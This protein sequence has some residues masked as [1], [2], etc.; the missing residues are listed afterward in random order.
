[1]TLDKILSIKTFAEAQALISRCKTPQGLF[2]WII[3]KKSLQ[4]KQDLTTKAF[5]A[6]SVLVHP[7]KNPAAKAR[8][9]IAF[10]ALEG[11]RTQADEICSGVKKKNIHDNGV[12]VNPVVFSTKHGTYTAVRR[13]AEGATCTVF[14]GTLQSKGQVSGLE[15]LMRVPNSYRDNDL[16]KREAVAFGVMRNKEKEMGKTPEGKEAAKRFMARLPGFLG[17]V[18]LEQPGVPDKKVVNTFVKPG[19]LDEWYTLVQIHD[20]YPD[21]LDPRIMCFIWN[22]ILEALTFT[23]AARIV[24]GA[25]TPN[26]ILVRPR[27][28]A[29]LL[30][31]WTASTMVASGDRV[32]YL[33]S[34]Y[35][36]LLPP[37][38]TGTVGLANPS[39]DIYTSAWSM[40]WLLGGEPVEQSIPAHVPEPFRQILNRCLQPKISSRYRNVSEVYEHF[41]QAAR[42]LWGPRK[43][44]ELTMPRAVA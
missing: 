37:E 9:E 7:D 16:M 34:K 42:G 31:D 3:T 11:F 8:A 40:V 21:G 17:S 39:S 15:V 32:P 4:E 23:H 12:L 18:E 10:K 14:E 35:C 2:P 36:T 24:H 26:H 44:V 25:L 19:N 33:D 22:R 28:H 29:G 6:L 27:D 30:I 13:I 5:R 41:Q 20:Q 1:M 38:I 43:F